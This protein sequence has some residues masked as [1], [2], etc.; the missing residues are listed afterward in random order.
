M[1]APAVVDY[2]ARAGSTQTGR[3]TGNDEDIVLDFHAY[4]RSNKKIS[5][6]TSIQLLEMR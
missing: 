6:D 2:H 3:T 5:K 4:S 1:R